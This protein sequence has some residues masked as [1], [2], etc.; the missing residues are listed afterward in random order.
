MIPGRHCCVLPVYGVE[1]TTHMYILLQYKMTKSWL[2]RNEWFQADTAAC[3]QSMLLRWLHTCI[4]Y[5]NIK[6]L[7]ADFWEMND[8]RQTLLRATSLWC[9]GLLTRWGQ[10]RVPAKGRDHTTSFYVALQNI[11]VYMCIDM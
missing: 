8:S 4:Y 11:H 10:Q 9:W 1:V 6:W 5:Y 7:K 3:Y 2:L